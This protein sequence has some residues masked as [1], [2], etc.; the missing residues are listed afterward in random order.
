MEND[1]KEY[2]TKMER[3]ERERERRRKEGKDTVPTVDGC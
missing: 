3:T 2:D 1:Y